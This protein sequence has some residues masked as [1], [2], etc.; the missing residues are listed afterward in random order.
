MTKARFFAA[1]GQSAGPLRHD[2]LRLSRR[3][4]GRGLLFCKIFA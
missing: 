3:A 2:Q 4:G 1:D